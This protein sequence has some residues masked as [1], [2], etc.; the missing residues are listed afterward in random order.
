MDS[1]SVTIGRYEIRDT[2]AYGGMGVLYLAFDP[3][4]DRPV[5]IK[6][7]RV[8]SADLRE[9][10]LREARLAAR[11]QHPNIVTVFDVGDHHGQPFIAMEYIAGETLAHIVGRRA[12]LTLSRRLALI[13]QVCVGLAYAH[14]HGI[15]HRDVK[16][17]N[18]MVSH[19][20]GVLKVLDFGVAGPVEVGG[21]AGG[22]LMGTPNY[23]SPEQVAGQT[24]DHR[25]D[26]FSVGLVL[27]ELIAYRQA[28]QGDSQQAILLKVLQESPEPLRSIVPDLD[29]SLEAI[30]NRA[31]EKAPSA[32]YADLDAMRADLSLV[33]QRLH[34]AESEALDLDRGTPAARGR[35][36]ALPKRRQVRV[37]LPP[38]PSPPPSRP[39]EP[40]EP[41]IDQALAAAEREAYEGR[42]AAAIRR[43]EALDSSRDDVQGALARYRV[44]VARPKAAG[45]AGAGPASDAPLAELLR[46]HVSGV[47]DALRSGRWADVRARLQELEQQLPPSA[48][49]AP[50][51]TPPQ[52]PA[53]RALPGRRGQSLSRARATAARSR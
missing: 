46:S 31:L 45:A 33:H 22:L 29:R 12:P 26:V 8:D 18:L 52:R 37:P 38:P 50:E 9:R 49:G 47:R 39:L 6:V 34:V 51:D 4:T 25:S 44:D 40:G 19:E 7:M 3:A 15:V 41:R 27:Y 13:D 14:R 24:A 11:L 32:R 5:A 20:S 16:P 35:G 42:Y 36:R 17:A 53:I 43:L 23:M 2:L 1:R 48:G 28:F 21:P 30:V 10:L